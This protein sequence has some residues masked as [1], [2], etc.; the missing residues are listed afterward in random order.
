V[1]DGAKLHVSNPDAE[2][3]VTD[4]SDSESFNQSIGHG[5]MQLGYRNERQQIG[6]KHWKVGVR[7]KDIFDGEFGK[8][9]EPG[10]LLIFSGE[11]AYGAPHVKQIHSDTYLVP[12]VSDIVEER[13]VFF[14]QN[15]VNCVRTLRIFVEE[16]D[17]KTH[18]VTLAYRL[19]EWETKTS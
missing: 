12:V 7:L 2:T 13:S 9:R 5:R 6:S 15:L 19:L 10:A 14:F 8:K 11:Q 18:S 4:V 1:V 17:T 3:L 16:I